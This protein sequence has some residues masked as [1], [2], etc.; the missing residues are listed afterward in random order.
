MTKT[1]ASV[2]R[3]IKSFPPAVRKKLAQIRK[4][5]REAAPNAEEII[6]YRMPA[7]RLEGILV[8]FAAFKNHIG[9]F[10]TASGIRFFEKDIKSYKH[11]KGTVQ[12]PLDKSVPVGLIKNIVKFRVKENLIKRS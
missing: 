10:P 8:Y 3:Y 6:S 11:S 5:V 12:F 4:A 1:S 2:D 9:F 7:Y